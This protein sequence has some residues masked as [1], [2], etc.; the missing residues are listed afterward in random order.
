M[1][2]PDAFLLEVLLVLYFF[3][4][5]CKLKYLIPCHATLN[6]LVCDYENI[7]WLG[8]KQILSINAVNKLKKD[9]KIRA[10]FEET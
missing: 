9:K 3:Q 4:K 7:Y 6:F 5:F 10:F 2:Q 1:Y 8:R